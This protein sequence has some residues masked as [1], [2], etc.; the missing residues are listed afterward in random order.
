MMGIAAGKGTSIRIENNRAFQI[1]GFDYGESYGFIVALAEDLVLKGN[2]AFEVMEGVGIYVD[3]CL[4]VVE[5][6]TST[7]NMAG[8]FIRTDPDR[9][10]DLSVLANHTDANLEMGLVLHRAVI[11]AFFDNTILNNG[12]AGVM[13][14]DY[15]SYLPCEMAGGGPECEDLLITDVLE[16]G[17]NLIGGNNPDFEFPLSFP[18]CFVSGGSI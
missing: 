4:G 16:C 3:E 15:L 5:G 11:S 6:N 9:D 17:N 7:S 8:M 18:D 2:L 13:D 14:M 12:G 1:T 10:P